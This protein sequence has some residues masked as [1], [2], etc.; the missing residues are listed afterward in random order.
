[1]VLELG[2]LSLPKPAKKAS[3]SLTQADLIAEALETEEINRASLLAFYAAEEDRRMADRIAGM[4]HEILGPK[5][6][7]L[8]RVEGDGV[9]RVKGK[10]KEVVKELKSAAEKLESGRRRLIEVIG[11]AGKEGWRPN[12]GMGDPSALAALA[13][14]NGKVAEAL[15]SG[16]NGAKEVSKAGR[17]TPIDGGL[18][19][20]IST[21]SST[22]TS[23]SASP[24]PP[25]IRSEAS[26]STGYV[27]NY[28]VLEN[29]EGTKVE[30]MNALFGDHHEWGTVKIVPSRSRVLRTSTLFSKS[31]HCTTKKLL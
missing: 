20:G 15:D 13:K 18:S 23:V 7:F 5:V 2:Q 11:E 19:N 30:E 16:A 25:P 17:P 3:V 24:A 31:M 6:S 8:S 29:F 12:S 9:E 10:A 27:R 14:S 26:V 28:L 1:M 4:R 22:L 21:M